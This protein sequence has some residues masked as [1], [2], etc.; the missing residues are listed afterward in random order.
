MAKKL[1]L[2]HVKS[3]VVNKLPSANVINYGE[4]AVNYN[5][6]S[7]ALAIKDSNDNIVKFAPQSYVDSNFVYDAEYYSS[8]S[9]HEIRLYDA[10]RNVLA[11]ID[12]DDFIKDG[13]V[14]DVYITGDTM[15]ITFNT[16][17]GHE[18]IELD[19]TDIFD[20]DIYY[21]KSEVDEKTVV[22]SAL[23]TGSTHPVQNKVVYQYILDNEL[24][25]AASLNDLNDR[26]A[27]K[28]YVDAA[29][30][31]IT[32][33]VDSVLDSASTNPVENRVIYNALN[34][35]SID[36]DDHMDSA[37]TNPVQNKVLWKVIADDEKVTSAALNDLENRKADKTYVDDAVENITIDVDDQLDSASTNPV[38]NRVVYNALEEKAD[39]DYVENAVEDVIDYVD[40]VSAVTETIAVT[41][42]TIAGAGNA[43][44][45]VSFNGKHLTL[46]KAII[47]DGGSFQETVSGV[48]IDG[49]GNTVIDAEFTDRNLTLTL[50]D[51]CQGNAKIF[52]GTCATAS[53]TTTK[54]VTCTAFTPSDLVKGATIFVTFSYKN[55]GTVANLKMDV[56]GTGAKPIKK[57]LANSTNSG[58]VSNLSQPYEIK[59]NQT[60]LFS[61]DG[62]NWVCLT[63]DYN[64]NTTYNPGTTAQ[65]NTGTDTTNRVWQPKMIADYVKGYVETSLNTTSKKPIATSAI[66]TTFYEHTGTTIPDTGYTS[67]QMHLPEVSAEDNGKILRVV[68]GEWVLVD[69]STVYSGQGAPAQ[70]LG[71]DG[72]IY[73]QTS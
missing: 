28:S 2:V 19:I 73:L 10:S 69:P 29:V 11:T 44:G 63:L 20:P 62:T 39:A 71:I 41:G 18:D 17:A 51:T 48:T 53:G 22:D 59:A 15:V 25:I 3:N 68:N 36:V 26:K 52:Y 21:T 56:N 54:S 27:D 65:L 8:G 40:E 38:E 23:D 33:D 46:T 57:L 16:D 14:H 9:T 24:A 34:N 37:S 1:H 61:Y 30:S 5:A 64:T 32:I 13:M 42:V 4:I 6:N 58:D 35:V 31:S 47:G 12:A 49:S 43:V 45:D 55:S 66:T 50:G 7:P 60:Y 72:D 70:N 67:S